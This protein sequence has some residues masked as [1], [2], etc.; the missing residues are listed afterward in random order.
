MGLV[1]ERA[2]RADIV[3]VLEEVEEME[4]LVFRR[5]LISNAI[6]HS[7]AHTRRLISNAFSEKTDWSECRQACAS[8]VWSYQQ[9]AK[10]WCASFAA[11]EYLGVCIR[12]GLVAVG[13]ISAVD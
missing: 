5:S 2:E 13:P 1:G 4:R 6:L 8:I 12:V 11:R 3:E 7:K 10:A 9:A